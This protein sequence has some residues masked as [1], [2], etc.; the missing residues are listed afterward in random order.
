MATP[1]TPNVSP[2][3]LPL[4]LT[5]GEP[6]GIGGEIALK[7]WKLNPSSPGFFLIDDIA[8]LEEMRDDLGIDVPLRT[9]TS[10]AEANGVFAEA[11]PVFP[12][13]LT[14]RA[15]LGSPSSNTA[16]SVIRSIEL[17]VKFV[18]DGLAAAVVTNPIQKNVLYAAGFGFPGHTEFLADLA[19]VETPPVMM[20]ACPDL[21][22]VPATVH[23][24]L[25]KAIEALS[26]NV[27]IEQTRILH[28]SLERDF[29]ISTPAIAVCGLN[30]HAGEDGAMGEEEKIVIT[31]AIEALIRE[32]IQVQG[33]Y[34]PDTL[35]TQSSRETYDAAVCM[36]H[37][38]ALIPI[39]TLDFAGAVNVTL[40]L[41]I[42][43]TSPDHGTAI[44]IAGKGIADPSSLV[45]AMDLARRMAAN[46]AVFEAAK[47]S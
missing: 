44:E 37:D 20:L 11:L 46:R 15:T 26:A 3:D 34:P 38:Q 33:P 7:S 45:N 27:I 31:P 43:R 36:Y 19:G 29:A 47:A 6:A 28:Q 42:I 8:R 4:A 17:A 18:T 39:K 5:M 40:G 9:I 21:R 30:P 32:G 25:K 22:V 10:P 35:F 23:V 12:C 13:P 41:P 24:G 16:S 2:P 14:D 1:N